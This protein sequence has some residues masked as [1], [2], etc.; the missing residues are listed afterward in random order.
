M[1]GPEV[2]KTTPERTWTDADQA[3]LYTCHLAADVLA[4]QQPRAAPIPSPFPPQFSTSEQLLATGPFTL[5]SYEAPGDGGYNHE[6]SFFFATGKAGLAATAGFAAARAAGNSRRRRRAL[7]DTIPRWVPVYSGT[8]TV[9]DE[10]AYLRTMQEFICWDWPMIR[11]A[12]IVGFNQGVLALPRADGR[13]GHW[14]LQ[15]Q[16]AELVFA[17]WAAKVYPSHP[18][19]ADGSWLPPNWLR[20]ARAQGHQLAIQP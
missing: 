9:S 15:S 16:F 10:G 11:S 17:V 18:Q 6:S 13:L 4:G 14:L 8:I 20:W 1:R 19:L 3:L 5:S 7:N 2:G 12:Q